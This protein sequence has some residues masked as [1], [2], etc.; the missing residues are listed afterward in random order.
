MV[1]SSLIEAT[2]QPLNQLGAQAQLSQAIIAPALWPAIRAAYLGEEVAKLNVENARR[3][4]LFGAA[5]L[6]YGAAALKKR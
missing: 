2:I 6:Y 4:V 1:P 5:Q 3:E